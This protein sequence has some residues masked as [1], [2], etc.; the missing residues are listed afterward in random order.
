MC[1]QSAL[2]LEFNTLTEG[3]RRVFRGGTHM[4]KCM[5]SLQTISLLTSSY[6]CMTWVASYTIDSQSS[7]SR[8]HA[9]I[10]SWTYHHMRSFH[11]DQGLIPSST[12]CYKNVCLY[13]YDC[14]VIVHIYRE[15]DWFPSAY[16]PSH[17]VSW[18]TVGLRSRYRK[19]IGWK[20]WKN[21]QSNQI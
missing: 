11:I 14:S 2:D 6:L 12:Y 17:G 1:S 10:S 15:V 3:Y 20:G 8:F 18:S 9:R 13:L 16:G 5:C 19:M 7:S 4:Q 21:I